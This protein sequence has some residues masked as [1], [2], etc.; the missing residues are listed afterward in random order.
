MKTVKI[1]PLQG[2]TFDE[3]RETARQI[4]RDNPDALLV[5]AVAYRAPGSCAPLVVSRLKES[6]EA[7]WHDPA[8]V[9]SDHLGAVDRGT[10]APRHDFDTVE[11]DEHGNRWL[12]MEGQINDSI[13]MHVIDL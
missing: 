3:A 8:Q 10:Y 2:K 11:Q 9:V 13:R 12:V 5:M 4:Q 1:K 6:E 7:P